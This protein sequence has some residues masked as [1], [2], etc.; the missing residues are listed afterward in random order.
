MDSNPIMLA[1]LVILA[2]WALFRGLVI[3]AEDRERHRQE[4]EEECTASHT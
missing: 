1:V 4:C 2:Y 3:I